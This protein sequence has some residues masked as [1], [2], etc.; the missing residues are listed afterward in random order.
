MK[1]DSNL[2]K[3]SRKMPRK[4]FM[5]NLER[6]IHLPSISRVAVSL[7]TPDPSG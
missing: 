6:L 5:E 2:L 3:S 7:R 1:N 4:T